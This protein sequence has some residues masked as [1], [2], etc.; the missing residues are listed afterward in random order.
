MRILFIADFNVFGGTRTYCEQLVHLLRDME[1]DV[2]ALVEGPG[3][4]AA[5]ADFARKHD[6]PWRS[7]PFPKGLFS[8]PCAVQAWELSKLIPIVIR[9]RPDFILV[10]VGRV[11]KWLSPFLLPIPTLHILHSAVSTPGR[12]QRPCL[13]VLLSRLSAKRR[14][15]TVSSHAVEQIKRHWR[16]DA[17]LIYNCTPYPDIALFPRKRTN[18][19]RV[20]TAG[21]VVAYKN[22]QGWL[23][24][25]QRVLAKHPSA[26]FFWHGDGPL[27]ETMRRQ[28]KGLSGIHFC[29]QGTDMRAAYAE[30][31]VYFQ[32]SL[33]ESHGI[34]VLEAMSYGLPC[35]V[36]D[37]GGLPESV[38]HD[39]TGY[40]EGADDAEAMSERICFL[41]E[42][43]DVAYDL[44]NSGRERVKA[45]FMPDQWSENIASILQTICAPGEFHNRA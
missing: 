7:L 8:R 40:V 4:N 29:G 1:A 26:S 44:G 39:V 6:V 45:H 17:S 36:S 42:N 31:A 23:N 9:Q 28:T 32:P 3:G 2:Y 14:L 18:G 10:S 41:L 5:F 25:A 24:V 37:R 21:H 16:C 19:M 35:V 12:L 22:P 27:L 33:L 38:I 30:A 34:A 15:V 20:M 43:P 13:A 11:G